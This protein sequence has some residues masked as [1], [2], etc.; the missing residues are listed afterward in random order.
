MALLQHPVHQKL[1]E[2]QQLAV[3]VTTIS[4]ATIISTAVVVQTY[5]FNVVISEDLAV[6]RVQVVWGT[7]LIVASDKSFA[8][9]GFSNH[10]LS[11]VIDLEC[12]RSNGI[13]EVVIVEQSSNVYASSGS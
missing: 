9:G 3:I 12:R 7:N 13:E 8:F 10:H 2:Y 1:R 11:S 4:H 6:G 5:L